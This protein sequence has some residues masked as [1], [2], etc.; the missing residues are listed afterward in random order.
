MILSAWAVFETLYYIFGKKRW[1]WRLT[2][3][4]LRPWSVWSL[5]SMIYQLNPKR[6]MAVLETAPTY[7]P[8]IFPFFAQTWDKHESWSDAAAR[9]AVT[10]TVW[11]WG[12]V[13]VT[14]AAILFL[15]IKYLLSGRSI[16]NKKVII[17]L[18]GLYII[19]GALSFSIGSLPNGVWDKDDQKGSLLSCWHAHNTVLYAVPFVQSKGHFLRN[20]HEIQ[21]QLRITIHA[22]SHPPGG[23]LSMYYL[24]KAVG[25]Q[26]MNIRLDSTRIRYAVGLIFFTALN[27]FVLFFMG[28]SMFGSNKHGFVAAMLWMVMP[29][30]LAYSTFAQDGLYSVFFN[31]AL[32]L[33]WQVC[34]ARKMPYVAMITL[35]LVFF[36]L[37]FLN[38]SWCLITLIFALF[39]LYCAKNYRWTFRTLAIRGVIP[40]GIMTVLS[41]YVLIHYKL[42]Y[43][44]AYKVSSE[45]VGQWYCFT[46]LYQHLIA[47][48]GGQVDLFL[49]M[50]AI[51]CSAF[52]ASVYAKVKERK[53]TPQLMFL[54]IILAVYLVPLLFGPTCI[55]LETA[56]CWMWLLSVPVCF[57]AQ[58]LL[59]QERASIFVISAVMFSLFTYTVMRLFLNFAP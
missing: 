41:G 58:F 57:A 17:I 40:L 18:A 2:S 25:A 12:A 15:I 43:L 48:V 49:M 42:D 26:G 55:R 16:S 50:G 33:S 24:G 34:T 19:A 11:G 31:L 45:Y 23:A 7:I 32:L 35:G 38:Y 8:N 4:V 1:Q 3:W 52:F 5:L 47:W 13:V 29:S 21:P 30:V 20:F 59:K 51:T 56:R 37:N 10:P 9:L 14:L 36:S 6:G 44:E 22:L 46:T 53:F 39:L 54:I 27:I 28:R